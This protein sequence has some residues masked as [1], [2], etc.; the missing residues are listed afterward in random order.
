MHPTTENA[1]QGRENCAPCDTR[2]AVGILI[3]VI[4]QRQ[5][6]AARSCG[7]TSTATSTG[8]LVFPFR[9]GPSSLGFD[10]V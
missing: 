8:D 5:N 4:S 7:G 3:I 2:G 9:I 6:K 10:P 1:P